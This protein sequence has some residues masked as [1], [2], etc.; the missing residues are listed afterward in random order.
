MKNVMVEMEMNMLDIV[1]LIVISIPAKD[2]IQMMI[3]VMDLVGYKKMKNVQKKQKVMVLVLLQVKMLV[4]HV[5]PMMIVVLTELVGYT[6]TQIAQIAMPLDIV[7]LKVLRMLVES[8]KSMMIVVTELVGKILTNFVKD[9]D[10]ELVQ[11]IPH[12]TLVDHVQPNLIVETKIL[13]FTTAK[14]QQIRV[15]ENYYSDNL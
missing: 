11:A 6:Q 1:M 14:L 15:A 4:K 5:L 9:L 7:P 10:L 3:V 2:V 13:V 12:K 8:A